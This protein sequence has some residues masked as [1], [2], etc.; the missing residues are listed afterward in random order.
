MERRNMC[1]GVFDEATTESTIKVLRDLLNTA[2][3]MKY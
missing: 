1:C 3:R 2:F